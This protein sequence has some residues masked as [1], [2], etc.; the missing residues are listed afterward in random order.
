MARPYMP[1]PRRAHRMPVAAYFYLRHRMLCRNGG[2][3]Y[4]FCAAQLLSSLA[5]VAVYCSAFA[6]ELAK[7]PEHIPVR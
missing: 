7:K 5:L 4:G 1:H 6:R 3:R 2:F